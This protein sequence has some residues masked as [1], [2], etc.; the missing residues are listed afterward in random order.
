M[1]AASWDGLVLLLMAE[2]EVVGLLIDVVADAETVR[3]I[4]L[5]G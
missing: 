2:G 3:Q 4:V 1:L 5:A